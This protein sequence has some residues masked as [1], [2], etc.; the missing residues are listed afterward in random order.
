MRKVYMVIMTSNRIKNDC[1]YKYFQ[2]KECN[3]K[4][5]AKAFIDDQKDFDSRLLKSEVFKYN[6]FIMEGLIITQE[7]IKSIID[8]SN[9]E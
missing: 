2:S 5:E 9:V 3:S 1:D 6:Y 8:N 7:K 4:K